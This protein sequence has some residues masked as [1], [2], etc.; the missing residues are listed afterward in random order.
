ML[1]GFCGPVLVGMKCTYTFRLSLYDGEHSHSHHSAIMPPSF[2]FYASRGRLVT[3][4]L[5][6]LALIGQGV[7][8]SPPRKWASR[9]NKPNILAV[10]AR[11]AGVL[12]QSWEGPLEG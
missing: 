3:R 4:D 1:K 10:A 8:W 12:A 5:H 2:H 7:K 11:P 6:L 9:P